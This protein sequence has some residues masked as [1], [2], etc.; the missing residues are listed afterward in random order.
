[1]AKV[2]DG[3]SSGTLSWEG[4]VHGT[5]LVTIDKGVASRGT[6]ISGKLPG[7][8]VFIQQDNTKKVA[9][10]AAPGQESNYQR[11]VLRVQGKGQIRVVLTWSLTP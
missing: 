2:P 1:M 4:T 3:P 6:L 9:I 10:A 8:P 7:K 11:L 5:E